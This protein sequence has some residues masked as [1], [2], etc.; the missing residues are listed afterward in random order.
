M[1]RITDIWQNLVR[2]IP[3]GQADPVDRDS[4]DG[5]DYTERDVLIEEAYKNQYWLGIISL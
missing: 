2:I 1:Q 3:T 4:S 5:D